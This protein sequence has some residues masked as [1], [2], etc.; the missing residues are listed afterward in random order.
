MPKQITRTTVE[1]VD[2]QVPVCAS[3]DQAVDEE[4][5]ITVGIDPYE[6]NQDELLR[7]KPK[8]KSWV[9]EFMCPT[10]ADAIFGYERP[11]THVG[12]KYLKPLTWYAPDFG[13]F[14][15]V[16][17]YTTAVLLGLLILALSGMVVT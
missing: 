13:F 4:E 12:R 10:C 9:R 6:V 7:D 14:T 11:E 8:R 1:A 17:Y 16:G 15:K 2:K 5:V 3:C